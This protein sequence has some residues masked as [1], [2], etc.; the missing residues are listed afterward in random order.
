MRTLL[1]LCFVLISAHAVPAAQENRQLPGRPAAR[2]PEWVWDSGDRNGRRNV[3]FSHAFELPTAFREARLRLFADF[4]G[5]SVSLNEQ[6][7]VLVDDF[8]PQLDL[9][10]T[11][12]L[13]RHKNTIRVRAQ[14]SDG[15]SAIALSVQVTTDEGAIK[16][17]VTDSSWLVQADNTATSETPQRK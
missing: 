8:G 17:I 4:A 11:N 3:V 15:P 6:S 10:V 7:V 13:R 14:G 9:D 2:T 1:T 16:T 12:F 5:C